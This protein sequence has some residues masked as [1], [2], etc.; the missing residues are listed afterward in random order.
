[1]CCN[2]CRG[3]LQVRVVR[4][5]AHAHPVEGGIIICLAGWLAID[6]PALLYCAVIETP[7]SRPTLTQRYPLESTLLIPSFDT[8]VLRVT[9]RL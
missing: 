7:H 3:Y 5:V 8:L 2:H 4:G 9:G 1:M 6:T